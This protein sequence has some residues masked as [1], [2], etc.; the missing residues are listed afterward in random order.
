MRSNGVGAAGGVGEV[1]AD[2]ITEGNTKF[3]MYNLDI[4][5]FI[6]IHNNRKF[7]HD[8]VKEVPGLIYAIPYPFKEY[9]TGRALRTSPIFTKLKDLGARF[10]QVMGYERPMYFN[11]TESEDKQFLG[12]SSYI[13]GDTDSSSLNVATSNT[14]FKPSWFESVKEEFVASRESVSLCDYSSFA[15]MDIWSGGLEVV[16]FLQFMCSNDIDIPIGHIIH[17]GMQVPN[18]SKSFS[19]IERIRFHTSEQGRRVRKR[20]HPCTP[21]RQPLH[22]HVSLNPANEILF[23]DETSSAH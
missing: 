7:L 4:Q 3:D 16:D 9:K 21:G 15:K 14:F 20:L 2:Y 11:K 19:N 23:M 1:I 10:N 18:I 8:R 5:R 6:A 22:A 17:T 13:Q 12:L